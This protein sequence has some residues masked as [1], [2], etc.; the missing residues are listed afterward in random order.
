MAKASSSVLK[1]ASTIQRI[2][3]KIRKPASQ[4][5]IVEIATRCGVT[6]R[7]MTL[8]L[9]IAADDADQEEG[10]D[11]GD[12]DGDEAACGGAADVILDQGLRVDQE[13][14]IGG[15]QT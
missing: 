10:H 11:V 3:K 14:D 13:G 15:L 6:M 4:A 12:D 8:C 7:A 9:Q 1:L 5:P 2:G